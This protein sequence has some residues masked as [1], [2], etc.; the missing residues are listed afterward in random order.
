MF[1]LLSCLIIFT[2]QSLVFLVL[3]TLVEVFNKII[4]YLT[5]TS[6]GAE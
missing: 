1:H 2:S 4:S 3:L 6:W 5:I